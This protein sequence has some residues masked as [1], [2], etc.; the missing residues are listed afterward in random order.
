[1]S[2]SLTIGNDFLTNLKKADAIEFLDVLEEK[3]IPILKDYS[4]DKASEYPVIYYSDTNNT[5]SYF[6]HLNGYE[7]IRNI[8]L[9]GRDLTNIQPEEWTR[10]L[11]NGEDILSDYRIR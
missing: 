1:M 4:H 7:L 8:V 11:N 5:D 3:Y 2:I 9:W 6:M 10:K